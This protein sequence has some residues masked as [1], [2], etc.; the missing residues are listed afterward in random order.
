MKSLQRRKLLFTVL[1][2]LGIVISA[3]MNPSPF[4]GLTQG[5][6]FLGVLL[7]GLISAMIAVNIIDR[8]VDPFF[9]RFSFNKEP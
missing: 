1:V 9:K 4:S 6:Q 3:T 7:V 8:I 5:W 2:A